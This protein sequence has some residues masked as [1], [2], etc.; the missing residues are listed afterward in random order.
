MKEMNAKLRW[1]GAIAS[2]AAL[3]GGCEDDSKRATSPAG[4]S[5]TAAA[6]SAGAHD[7]HGHHVHVAPHGGAIVELEDEVANVELL[8]DDQS[9]TLTAWLLDGCLEHALRSRQEQLE[10]VITLPAPDGA[11][12]SIFAMQLA[13]A[14]NPLTGET[15]G[16]TSQFAARHEQLRGAKR[17]K[18]VLPRIVLRSAEYNDVK[19][20]YPGAARVDKTE[21]HADPAH[22]QADHPPK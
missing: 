15:V 8:L 11:G 17:F 6:H 3:L 10:V 18:G 5:K 22:Q 4:D 9:G 20:D 21:S 1:L 16:D 13:A 7:E 12:E 14:A 2:A 19:F